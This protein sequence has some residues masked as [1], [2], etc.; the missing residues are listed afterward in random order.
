MKLMWNKR[1][2]WL[3]FLSIA[4]LALIAFYG[5]MYLLA[6][7]RETSAEIKQEVAEQ[8]SLLE[9]YP[10]EEALLQEHQRAYEETQVF[11]PERE[12]IN[13]ALLTLE[14]A[15][16]AVKVTLNQVSSTG[17][18][19]PVESLG[20]GYMKS[21]YGVEMTSESAESMR[22]L[23]ARLNELERVWNI[24]S[25]RY[26]KNGENSYTGSLTFELYYHNNK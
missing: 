20:D 14:S 11:L 8:Q 6:P 18:P 3:I 22:N 25:F 1:S 12:N 4:L 10:P 5:N 23:L 13:E 15:A 19:Q 21:G 16:S 24:T 17:D 26:E 9:T 2:G 7:M